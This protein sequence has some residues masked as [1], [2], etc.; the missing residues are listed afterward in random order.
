[1]AISFRF[2]PGQRINEG[3]L[4]ARLD[5]SR[6]P[7][8]EALQKLVAE[9]LIYWKRGYGFYCRPLDPGEI[10][11]L[12]ELRRALEAFAVELACQ[13]ASDDELAG[14]DA[15]LDE[16]GKS[17]QAID[18]QMRLQQSFHEEIARLS[19]NGEIARALEAINARI[20][21][22]RWIAMDGRWPRSNEEHRGIV[23]AMRARDP[24]K[25]GSIMRRHLDKRPEEI[26]ALVRESY[27]RIYTGDL[28]PKLEPM[29]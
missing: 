13:R 12:Y 1:M 18:E 3:E 5:V 4:A 8:R 15:I 14:L 21:F 10:L 20:Y 24:E 29:T 6:T 28:P 2:P 26:N 25:A 23:A 11:E 9:N 22:V 17:G 16:T 19:G 27:A 7:V